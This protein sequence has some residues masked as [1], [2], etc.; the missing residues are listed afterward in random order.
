MFLKTPKFWYQ[1]KGVLSYALLPIAFI[2]QLVH[3]VLLSFKRDGYKSSLPVICIGN[4]VAGGSGKTPTV[5]SLLEIIKDN[6]LFLNPY[7]L[8]RGYGRNDTDTKLVNLKENIF[9]EVGDEALFLAEHAPVIVGS[10]RGKSAQLAEENGA[11]CLILDD[12]LLNHSLKKDVSILV[13]DRNMDFGNGF[14]IPAG[15]LRVPL[16]KI[17]P[18]IDTIIT[19]GP[20]FLSDKPVFEGFITPDSKVKE[21]KYIAFAGIGYPQKFKDFLEDNGY[22]LSDWYE[23]PD[24]HSYSEKDIKSLLD[25][26]KKENARLITTEKDFIRIPSIYKEM[27][28]TLP[29]K[30]SIKDS[31]KLAEYLQ[32]NLQ[33]SHEKN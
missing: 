1:K 11:D 13:V 2:Y 22:Y 8:T 20:Q 4:A 17:L 12:G 10:D 27:V 33:N 31:K 19:I 6:N 26:A 24:H 3:L 9:S 15:P 30:L 21:E 5:L 29:I 16:K 23:F 7:I 25:K 14:T 18:K 28:D 32:S